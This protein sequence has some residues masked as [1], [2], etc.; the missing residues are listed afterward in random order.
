M[1]FPVFAVSVL[2][3]DYAVF[4]CCGRFGWLSFFLIR[5]LCVILTLAALAT[6]TRLILGSAWKK[7]GM[8]IASSCGACA[9]LMSDGL[10]LPVFVSGVRGAVLSVISM[11]QLEAM[12]ARIVGPIEPSGRPSRRIPTSELPPSLR[13]LFGHR[14]LTC[15]D[16]GGMPGEEAILTVVWKDVVFSFGLQFGGRLGDER[17][18]LVHMELSPSVRLFAQRYR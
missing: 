5:I 11:E 10:A 6:A 2:L 17:D 3:V 4:W 12:P 1:A 14:E 18:F 16:S 7:R 13:S 15:S 8:L 9:V